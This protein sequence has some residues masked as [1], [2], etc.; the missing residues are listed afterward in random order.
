MKKVNPFI[1]LI[2][3]LLF[4]VIW[5]VKDYLW[6]YGFDVFADILMFVLIGGMVTIIASVVVSIITI[7]RSRS[8]GYEIGIMRVSFSVIIVVLI[9]IFHFS[10]FSVFIDSGFYTGGLISINSKDIDEER[11]YFEV[12]HG[13]NEVVRLECEE[14]TYMQLLVDEDV[15]YHME[16]RWL[17][18]DDKGVIYNID[19]VDFIDNRK[20]N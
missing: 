12:L 7:L 19:I 11:Y 20:A 10:I 9:A 17:I 1:I 4:W 13:D 2:E 8:S 15:A 5:F 14:D 16:Y 18:Y 6:L 3:V